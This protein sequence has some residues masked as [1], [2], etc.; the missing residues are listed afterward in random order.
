MRWVRGPGR[1]PWRACRATTGETAGR[2][3][4]DRSDGPVAPVRH[5]RVEGTAAG[6]PG[7]GLD[8]RADTA[9]ADGSAGRPDG[10][11]GPWVGSAGPGAPGIVA[12]GISSAAA[13][14]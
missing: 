12:A 9:A 10:S 3:G 8:D 4:G 7:R 14:S 2:T 6:W 5:A 11:A 1:A 13:R